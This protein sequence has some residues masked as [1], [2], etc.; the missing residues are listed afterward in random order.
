MKP[1]LIVFLI[2]AVLFVVGKFGLGRKPSDA[3]LVNRLAKE[4]KQLA[5]GENDPQAALIYLKFE[6]QLY[7]LYPKATYSIEGLIVSQHRSDSAF[8]LAH[9]RSGDTLN[10]RDLCTIWGRTLTAGVYQDVDFWSGDWTCYFKIA[11]QDIAA[12]FKLDEVSNTHV[13]AKDQ[14]VRAKIDELEIGDEYRMTGRLVDYEQAFGGRRNSS[15][16]RTDTGNGACEIMYVESVEILR[17]HNR[18]FATAKV[19]GFWTALLAFA[20]MLGMMARSIFFARRSAGS[21]ILIGFATLG[22]ANIVQARICDASSEYCGDWGGNSSSSTSS[23]SRGGKIRI[24]PSVIPIAKGFGA[25]FLFFDGSVDFALVKGLGRIGAA[26]SPSNSDETFFGPPGFEYIDDFLLRKTGA[27]K[28][29][30]QKVTLATAFGLFDNRK[31]GMTKLSLNLGVMGKYNKLSGAVYPGGGI[32]GVAGP[33]TFGYSRYGDQSVI[34]TPEIIPIQPGRDD[35]YSYNV[36][37]FSFGAYIDALAVDYSVL[38]VLGETTGSQST[39]SVLTGTWLFKKSLI[40]LA[41]RTDKYGTIRPVFNFETSQLEYSDARVE[42]FGG[43]QVAVARP[44]LLGIF[45]NYYLVRDISVGA[46]LFF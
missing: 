31:A 2:G 28:F 5:L 36:E 27:H 8:D 19:I 23:S 4:P 18:H 13:L 3:S 24:N 26:I 10:S 6:N 33:L 7:T 12:S 11:S 39:S 42:Y 41:Q 25:E 38:R 34:Q 37:T 43:L 32:S 46:T 44:L 45:Y 20:S 17:S 29:P 14:A 35:I 40:T 15:L 9:S 30:N 16:V 22:Y 21:A 1:A